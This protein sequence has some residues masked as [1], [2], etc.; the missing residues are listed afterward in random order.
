MMADALN[1]LA[2]ALL[3]AALFAAFGAITSRSLFATCLYLTAAAAAVAT[4]ILLLGAGNGA[5]AVVL[6]AAA[7]T[8]VLL[9]AAMLL[10]ARVTKDGRRGVPWASVATGAATLMAVWWPLSELSAQSVAD[11]PAASL[12]VALWLAPL[13]IAAV[14]GVA[15]LLGY[16]ER[17]ALSAGDGG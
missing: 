9:L 15:A 3:V 4:V 7:W 8:P 1:L 2:L 13:L 17:G 16:G 5:L 6:I 14:A 10:S 11:A 12:N